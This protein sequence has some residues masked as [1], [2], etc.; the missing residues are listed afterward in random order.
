MIPSLAVRSYGLTFVA[1][2]LYAVGRLAAARVHD[3]MKSKHERMFGTFMC[4]AR[5]LTECSC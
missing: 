1:S 5:Y 4:L 3:Q 2:W